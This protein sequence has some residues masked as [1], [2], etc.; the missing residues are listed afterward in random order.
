V[1]VVGALDG[2]AA[3]LKRYT[4]HLDAAVAVA[5]ALRSLVDRDVDLGA[6]DLVHAA[7]VAD[8]G[9]LI[10]IEIEEL[11]AAFDAAGGMDDP[12]AERAALTTLVLLTQV[13]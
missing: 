8:A 1:T 9:L 12:I 13:R 3:A 2:R 4:G 11:T 10:V 5:G 6:E 7:H